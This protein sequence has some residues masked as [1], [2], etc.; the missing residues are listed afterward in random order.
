MDLRERRELHDH[1]AS[2]I[3][4]GGSFRP[5]RVNKTTRSDSGFLQ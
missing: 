4:L 2:L 3:A 1:R 5:M